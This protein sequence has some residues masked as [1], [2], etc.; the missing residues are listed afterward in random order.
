MLVA[1]LLVKLI[2]MVRDDP[3]VNQLTVF[4][5]GCDCIGEADQ[6]GAEETF[7]YDANKEPERVFVI[8]R[9]HT[10]KSY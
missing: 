3:T 10:S 2:D 9:D 7:Y 4:S 8:Y 5:E 1:E 6:V